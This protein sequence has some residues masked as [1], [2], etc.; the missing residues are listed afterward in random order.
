MIEDSGELF[1]YELEK[2]IF[3]LGRDSY[4]IDIKTQQPELTINGEELYFYLSAN[5]LAASEHFAELRKANVSKFVL[6]F[7][8]N[9]SKNLGFE[10]AIGFWDGNYFNDF[11]GYRMYPEPTHWVHFPNPPTEL[12]EALSENNLYEH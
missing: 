10:Y 2:P 11:D 3:S 5:G 12:G 8:R 7:G 9:E 4:W 6:T 1:S